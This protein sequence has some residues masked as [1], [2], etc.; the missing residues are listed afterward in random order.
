VFEFVSMSADEFASTL[1]LK[2]ISPDGHE[3]YPGELTCITT[4]SL[5]QNN[6]FT[7]HFQALTSAPT[8]INLCNHAYWN[9]AGHA[10]GSGIFSL[11][12]EY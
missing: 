7:F 4:F 9:L 2:I 1:V 8:V 5:S 10:A 6:F 12:I 11:T 3:G